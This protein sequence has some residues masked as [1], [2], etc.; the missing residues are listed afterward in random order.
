MKVVKKFSEIEQGDLR[1]Q[2]PDY[3]FIDF[4]IFPNVKDYEG[5]DVHTRGGRMFPQGSYGNG[6]QFCRAW[7]KDESIIEVITS[8]ESKDIC[9]AYH[10]LLIKNCE[11]KELIF[12]QD[13]IPILYTSDT[14]LNYPLKEGDVLL[15]RSFRYN[16]EVELLVIEES[17]YD[18]PFADIPQK[19]QFY[20]WATESYKDYNVRIPG[21]HIIVN[22]YWS[23]Y[24]N[25]PSGCTFHIGAY[26]TNC[27]LLEG[28]KNPVRTADKIRDFHRPLYNMLKELYNKYYGDLKKEPQLYD[29]NYDPNMGK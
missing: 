11:L 17:P 10:E 23:Q 12:R 5:K 25:E 18:K 28:V 16:N 21:R 14:T 9:E 2:N 1:I 3:Y 4:D 8:D 20:E 22:D 13:A 29:W 27:F 15:K 7:W 6:K 24:R 26:R 19:E